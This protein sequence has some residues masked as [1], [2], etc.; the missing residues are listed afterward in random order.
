MGLC[1][2]VYLF[3]RAVAMSRAALAAENLALRHQVTVL[4]R[5]VKRPTLCWRDRLFW[6]WLS[7]LWPNWRSILRI[8]QPDTVVKWH[9]LG[10]RLYWRC[11]SKPR[12]VGRPVIDQAI[13]TLIRRMA[14]ENLTWGAPRIQAEL[15]FL[16]YRVAEA[17]VAKYMPKRRKPP[18][19]TWRTFLANHVPDMA[20]IDFFTVPTLTFR[21]LYGFLVLRHD[22]RQVVHFNVTEHPTAQWTAQQIV[23]AFPFDTAPRYLIRDRDTVY[24]ATFQHRIT[25]MGIQ[26]TPTAPFSPWQNPY[27]ER[28]IGT[29]RRKLLDQVIVLNEA[30]LRRLMASYLQYYHTCR[31]HMSL[32]RNAPIPRAMQP[33]SDGKVVGIPHVGGLHYSYQRAA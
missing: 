24:S 19:Q 26:D 28:M 29:L 23:E 27:A 15:C 20:A 6:V 31:P 33:S 30:H 5:T 12:K 25:G 21:L 8:V 22:R 14:Q 32:E 3:L 7:R 11:T 9:Q 1:H 2:T 17:T 18:S 10:F 4:Q 13:R 16:G